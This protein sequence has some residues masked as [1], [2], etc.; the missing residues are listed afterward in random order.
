M[1]IVYNP[2]EGIHDP[3]NGYNHSHCII[4][5][6]DSSVDHDKAVASNRYMRVE[7][8]NGFLVGAGLKHPVACP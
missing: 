7:K 6:N 5:L 1:S 3:N 2:E 8:N 4:A